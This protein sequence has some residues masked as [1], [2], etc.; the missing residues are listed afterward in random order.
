M[1]IKIMILI[2]KIILILGVQ[3]FDEIFGLVR[4]FF[5]TFS[6]LKIFMKLFDSSRIFLK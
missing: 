1:K 5:K 3:K 2:K 4:V 6:S